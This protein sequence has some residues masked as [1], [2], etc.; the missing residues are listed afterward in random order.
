MWEISTDGGWTGE[1][2]F[3]RIVREHKGTIYTI[4]YMFSKDEADRKKRRNGDVRHP[5]FWNRSRNFRMENSLTE[6]HPVQFHNRA[7]RDGGFLVGIASNFTGE[8]HGIPPKNLYL[9]VKLLTDL[10]I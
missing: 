6:T 3:A 5:K 1:I 2:D 8:V 7:A 9:R 10:Q 4:C